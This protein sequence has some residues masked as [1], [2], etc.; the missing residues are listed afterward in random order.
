MR[1]KPLLSL[2]LFKQTKL[3]PFFEKSDG[4]RGCLL[5]EGLFEDEETATDFAGQLGLLPGK[6]ELP[7]KLIWNVDAIG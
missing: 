3:P 7:F 5:E 1:K 2:V 6:L 4:R